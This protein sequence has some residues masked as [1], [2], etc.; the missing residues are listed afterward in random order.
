[1]RQV[2]RTNAP[3]PIDR[4]ELLKVLG[5]IYGATSGVPSRASLSGIIRAQGC[6]TVSA[7][8]TPL[9]KAL[10]ESG[11]LTRT[12]T[13]CNTYKYYWDWRKFGPPSLPM[14]DWMIEEVTK[15]KRKLQNKLYKSRRERGVIK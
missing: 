5:K 8:Q 15:S 2:F 14:C 3:T 13:S 1:M 6:P 11:L 7:K 9:V 12:G 10:V 4:M